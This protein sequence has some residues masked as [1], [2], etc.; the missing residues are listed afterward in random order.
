RLARG[1]LMLSR[2]ASRLPAM[3]RVALIAHECGHVVTRAR[4]FDARE[5]RGEAEWAS[6]M[7]A[8]MYAFRWGF[9]KQIREHATSRRIGHH[10]AVPGETIW[11]GGFAYRVDGR[12]FLRP[13]PS[14]DERHGQKHGQ[15]SAES[16]STA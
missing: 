5:R 14:L 4:D 15:N 8:D 10:D 11:D 16:D 7:C 3:R 9:E 2:R 12:F 13:C 1:R 6:E